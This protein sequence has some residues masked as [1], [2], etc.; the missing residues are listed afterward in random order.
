MN[1]G[2]SAGSDTADGVDW[3]REGAG[4]GCA[5]SVL[6]SPMFDTELAELMIWLSCRSTRRW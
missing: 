5:G 4:L 2:A 3:L 6:D 1:G